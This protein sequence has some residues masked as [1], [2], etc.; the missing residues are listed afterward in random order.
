[1]SRHPYDILVRPLLT[2]K[3][4]LKTSNKRPQYVFKVAIDSNKIQI[5]RAVEAAFNVKVLGVNTIRV[6]GKL[7]RMRVRQAGR[8]PDWKKAIVTL[9]E[10]Q[11]I[12]LI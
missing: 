3:A 5:R 12:N 8:R 9:A 7:K 1:M 4:G 6:E 11:T 10:G 2:E